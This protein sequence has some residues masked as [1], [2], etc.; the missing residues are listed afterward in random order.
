MANMDEKIKAR[1]SA[2]A[3][4]S[5]VARVS[6]DEDV[7]EWLFF[8]RIAMIFCIWAIMI[9]AVALVVSFRF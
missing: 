5:K 3:A 8:G 9:I 2:M 7:R 4:N 1:I 6:D